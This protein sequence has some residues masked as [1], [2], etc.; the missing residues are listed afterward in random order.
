MNAMK[1]IKMSV[2]TTKEMLSPE[3]RLLKPLPLQPLS[4]LLD[5]LMVDDISSNYL[6]KLLD[7]WLVDL[8]I[9]LKPWLDVLYKISMDLLGKSLKM[10][11]ENFKIQENVIYLQTISTNTPLDS[12]FLKNVYH[13]TALNDGKKATYFMQIA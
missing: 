8:D 11:R 3:K 2:I 6:L 7:N 5:D 12:K 13:G 10:D 4:P 1:D 9:P